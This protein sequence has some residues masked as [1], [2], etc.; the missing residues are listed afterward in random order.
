MSPLPR[1]RHGLSREQ[2]E[3]S[4]R[5]R[6]VRAM[7]E[8]MAE[9]GYARTSVADILRRARVSRETFYELFDSKEDCF[10]SAFE[11]AYGH[12]L[13]AATPSGGGAPI[14]RFSQLLRDYLGALAADPAAARVFLVEVYAAE[15][16]ALA[17]RQELQQG[18]VQSVAVLTG[19]TRKQD[20][21]AIDA[22]LAALVQMVTARVAVG[23]VDGLRKLHTP[24]VALARRLGLG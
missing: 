20:R 22:L 7:C 18:L 21:F 19:A 1:G 11:E 12:L 3:G 2:V 10:M 23:D 17:R 4:Q 9:S 8:V 14:D 16:S 6:L 15:P 24:M 5:M 13:D